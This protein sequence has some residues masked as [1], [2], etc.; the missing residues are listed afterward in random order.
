MRLW[1]SLFCLAVIA[2]TMTAAILQSR[3]R[4]DLWG[5][6]FLRGVFFL[7]RKGFFLGDDFFLEEV[8]LRRGVFS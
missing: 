7:R 3:F 1:S 8:F 4:V 6:F 2:L 5:G